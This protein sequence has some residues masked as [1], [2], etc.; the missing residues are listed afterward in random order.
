MVYKIRNKETGLY[1]LGGAY[2]KWSRLG[3]VWKSA[4]ALS[5][6]FSLYSSYSM[7]VNMDDWVV[8]EYELQKVR[9]RSVK[10]YLASKTTRKP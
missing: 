7:K 8:E 3:K 4:S 5:L 9:E 2:Y 1:K 10:D 6:H